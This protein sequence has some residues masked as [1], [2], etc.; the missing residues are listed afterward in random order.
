MTPPAHVDVDSY[1]DRIGFDGEV[2]KDRPTLE[3][4][5]RAHLTSVP[6][7]N[8]DVYARSGV[9]TEL[10]WSLDKIVQRGRGGWCF[11]LNGAFSALLDALGFP[12]TRM[13]ATVLEGDTPSTTPN[14]LTLRVDLDRPYL[15]DVGFGASGPIR[16][17]VL[18]RIDAQDGGFTEFRISTLGSDR[19]LERLRSDGSWISEFRFSM[20]DRE[21]STFEP[22]SQ[23]LQ[24]GPGHFTAAPFATR[25]I[26]GGPDRVSLTPGRLVTHH[27]EVVEES[28]VAA[29][30]WSDTLRSRFGIRV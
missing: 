2:E 23:R 10:A 11:E 14:H 21:M 9:R 7:E 8:L 18:D 27:G 6:F 5:Q 17:L 29:A 25:L 22:A 16:P 20:V 4:L 3:A 12:M 19:V 1:L 28:P 15:V 30:E 24:N 13:A 26:D